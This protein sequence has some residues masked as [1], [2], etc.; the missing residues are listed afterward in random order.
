MNDTLHYL[1]NIAFQLQRTQWTHEAQYQLYQN[2]YQ[3]LREQ[4][5][6]AHRRNHPL[7][8]SV[9]DLTDA[10]AAFGEYKQELYFLLGLQ[11]GLELREIDLVPEI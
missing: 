7:I 4:F 6:T 9:N 2:E 5:H 1:Y 8:R 11:M 3:Q 10:Q